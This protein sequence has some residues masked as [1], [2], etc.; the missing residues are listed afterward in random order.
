MY[1][2]DTIIQCLGPHALALF[3]DTEQKC[4]IANKHKH[5]HDE[6]IPNKVSEIQVIHVKKRKGLINNHAPH[7]DSLAYFP[8]LSVYKLN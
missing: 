4:I 6:K 7:L 5:I 1:N 8:L 3:Y 2:N